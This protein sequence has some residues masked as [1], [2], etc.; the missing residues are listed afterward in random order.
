MLAL[1]TGL[2]LLTTLVPSHKMSARYLRLVLASKPFTAD[3]LTEHHAFRP[4]AMQHVR[5]KRQISQSLAPSA[6]TSL[7][8]LVACLPMHAI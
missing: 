5:D 6:K 1:E 8:L 4:T 7:M 2:L 3:V